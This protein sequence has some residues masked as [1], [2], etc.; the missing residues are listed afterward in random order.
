MEHDLS[1]KNSYEVP[2][3][4]DK[5]RSGSRSLTVLDS[6]T[7]AEYTVST[8][9]E[10]HLLIA[11]YEVNALKYHSAWELCCV[12]APLSPA[13]AVAALLQLTP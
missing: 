3:S 9:N 7:G 12:S 5:N 6:R 13:Y 10:L 1:D 11:T 2:M 4:A 8:R